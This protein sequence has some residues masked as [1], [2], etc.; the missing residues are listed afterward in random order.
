M[1]CWVFVTA[2]SAPLLEPPPYY[3][4]E[5]DAV[6]SWHDACY[7]RHAWTL[8]RITKP[9]TAAAATAAAT[10]TA[11][12]GSSSSSRAAAVFAAALL[13]GRVLG[14]MLGLQEVLVAPAAT[15]GRVEMVGVGRVGELLHA[16][17][18]KKVR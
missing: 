8:P 13:G 9:L 1:L 11:G 18:K 2:V 4:P 7:S 16:L 3:S 17:E 15:A 5:A 6:L 12:L 14:G 10:A